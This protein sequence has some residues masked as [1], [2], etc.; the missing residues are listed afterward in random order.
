MHCQR[1]PAEPG[2]REFPVAADEADLQPRL[3]DQEQPFS[4]SAEVDLVGAPKSKTFMRA[5]AIE[6]PPK[7]EGGPL[8]A[9]QLRPC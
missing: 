9:S 4:F 2:D 1:G 3:I 7:E 6:P 8:A 5:H